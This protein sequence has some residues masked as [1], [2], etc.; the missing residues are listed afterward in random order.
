R[1]V[2]QGVRRSRLDLA[3]AFESQRRRVGGCVDA[4]R[5]QIQIARHHKRSARQRGSADL[6]QS[7]RRER[8]AG[9]D[10]QR[11]RAVEAGRAGREGGAG[12][13]QRQLPAVGGQTR[14]GV[15]VVRRVV[16]GSTRQRQIRRVGGD[17]LGRAS[18]VQV[19]I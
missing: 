16:D 5:G 15:R 7:R 2:G 13:R 17:G 10:R 9:A 14:Q 1:K 18:D 12:P 6:R 11:A 19:R 8:V 4:A 3:A